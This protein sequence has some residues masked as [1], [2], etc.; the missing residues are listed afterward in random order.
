MRIDRLELKGGIAFQFL[1]KRNLSV[2]YNLGKPSVTACCFRRKVL[3]DMYAIQRPATLKWLRA[4]QPSPCA[5]LQPSAL[6]C[7]RHAL[8]DVC[9]NLL[10]SSR[11][12]YLHSIKINFS[13]IAL[14]YYIPFIVHLMRMISVIIKISKIKNPN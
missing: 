6:H 12:A 1:P 11:S 10:I 13:H 9:H 5:V 4:Q 3:F 2:G 14:S 7:T 8:C